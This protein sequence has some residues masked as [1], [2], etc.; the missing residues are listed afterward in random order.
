MTNGK[1]RSLNQIKED[2]SA[3]I[4]RK[5]LPE[6]WVIHNYS[7]DYGIDCIVELFEYIDDSKFMAETL[8]ESFYVQLKAS[9]SLKYTNRTAFARGNVAKAEL[10]ENKQEYTKID[11]LSFNLDVSDLITVQRLGTAIPV[12]LV[13]VDVI[14]ERIFFV[15]LNDYIDKVLI[16]EDPIFY[17]KKSKQIYI[18]LSN[19]ITTENESLVPLRTYSKRAKMY[20][21][22]SKFFYQYSE[23]GRM[24]G[25]G[26]VKENLSNEDK[27]KFIKYFAESC[28]NNDIWRSHE[29]WQ[30]ISASENEI[31][32]V[33][34]SISNG[35]VVSYEIHFIEYCYNHVWRR[36]VNLANMYEEIVREWFLP[37]LLGQLLSNPNNVNIVK[38]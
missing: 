3:R 27:I 33:L 1:R 23:I 32:D 35:T 29:F 14:T 12:L 4:F 6:T 25:Q 37:T 10:I 11:I 24:I 26:F 15:C 2:S 28:L 21:A 31:I 7:P 18:P 30:P 9:D 13:V 34:T 5:K 19:E 20:G 38:K 36:L 22:F 17:Q 8:G 16:P